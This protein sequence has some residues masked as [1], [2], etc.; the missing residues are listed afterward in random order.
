MV[1]LAQNRAIHNT[2]ALCTLSC[3]CS[4][5][6]GMALSQGQQGNTKSFVGFS[7][8]GHNAVLTTS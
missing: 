7:E 8:L 3:L 5:Q 6:P 2:H 1:N 4:F